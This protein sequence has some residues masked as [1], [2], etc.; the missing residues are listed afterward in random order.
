MH[1]GPAGI[2]SRRR[3]RGRPGLISAGHGS[4]ATRSG[5]GPV[6]A[7]RDGAGHSSLAARSRD[8]FHVR[9]RLI[10]AGRGGR[11]TGSWRL[12]RGRPGL[13]AVSR[14]SLATRRRDPFRS[15]RFRGHPGLT[16]AGHDGAGHSSLATRSRDR[17]RSRR[18]FHS[19]PG[20]T[21]AGHDGAGHGSAVVRRRDRFRAR[22]RLIVAGHDGRAGRFRVRVRAIGPGRGRVAGTGWLL[23]PGR[24]RA[25]LGGRDGAHLRP[26]RGNP[27]PGGGTVRA[28]RRLVIGAFR[29]LAR[30]HC[31]ERRRRRGTDCLRRV[32]VRRG[33]LLGVRSGARLRV[34]ARQRRLLGG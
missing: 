32:P 20:L 10:T 26:W 17:F 4:R 28:G 15:R 11:A 33:G 7:G 12:L 14:G 1:A 23:R 25:G 34:P 3:S 24:G 30:V 16:A 5:P 22:P 9:S 8:R 6:A 2:L 18:R 21:A 13:A 31:G 29:G 27:G 19:H